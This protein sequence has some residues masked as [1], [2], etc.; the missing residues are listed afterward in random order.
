MAKMR[1]VGVLLLLICLLEVQTVYAKEYVKCATYF[2]DACPMNFWNSEH[3]HM[4]EDFTRI[5][6]D[7]FNGIILVIPWREF[8][9]SMS[10]ISY[11]ERAFEKLEQVM[12]A[13]GHAGLSVYLRIGY[14]WDYYNTQESCLERYRQIVTDKTVRNAWLD[15][16]K[17]MYQAASRHPNFAG[18]FMT[19][20]DFWNVTDL[21]F[22]DRTSS[23]GLEIA[24]K[25]GYVAY[26]LSHYSIEELS[27]L[28]E[29]PLRESTLP[30]PKSGTMAMKVFYEYY[31]AFLID[32]LEETQ[33]VFPELSME[34]RTD[35]DYLSS[36]DGQA[37]YYGHQKT[38]EAGQASYTAMMYGIPMG[39]DNQGQTVSAREAVR[40]TEIVFDK[41]RKESSKPLFVEQFLF[42]DTTPGYENN[43]QIRP[44]ELNLYLGMSADILKRYSMGYGIWTYQNYC[45]NKL[46]NAQFGLGDEHWRRND[47]TELV[48]QNENQKMLL[49]K[50][51]MISQFIYDTVPSHQPVYVEFLAECEGTAE[52]TVTVGRQKQKVC[53]SGNQNV[54]LTFHGEDLSYVMWESDAEVFLD[55]IKV[56]TYVQ[57][58]KLYDMYGQELGSMDAV[59]TINRQLS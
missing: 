41:I 17:T 35:A 55:N 13:A 15:Y 27:R 3:V 14:V 39:F 50:G 10:P 19:W 4:E 28:Y 12:E 9:P 22:V 23:R 46:Y 53:I 58:G 44:E 30:F 57:D 49:K 1:R 47:K 29:E 36:S 38:Y 2:S 6:Q 54:M 37:M 20:E 42:V 18:G 45:D 48:Y 25:S 52:V 21:S 51:G 7:G 40:M 32:L 11:N 8:Q 59:R 33:Q 5:V 31:D 16:A 26:A 24:Q 56:Y 34:V 43:V